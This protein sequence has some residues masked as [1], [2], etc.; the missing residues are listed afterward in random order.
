MCPWFN[1]K[2]YHFFRSLRLSVRTRDFHSLKSSSILL[3][4]TNVQ[5]LDAGFYLSVS[6]TL[7]SAGS[8]RLPY[9]QRVGGS[10][11]SASTVL[12]KEDLFQ[13]QVPFCSQ[14]PAFW[15]QNDYL[16]TSIS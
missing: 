4:T 9:K 12:K 15:G 1:S 8:E 3:G 2:R 7:S 5:F 10:N 16:E 14:N 13:F 11:P 6:W